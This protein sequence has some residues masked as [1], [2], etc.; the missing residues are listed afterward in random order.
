MS[1]AASPIVAFLA[2]R[3]A[4][5]ARSFY[6]GTLGLRIIDDTP[7]ALVVDAHGTT[8]RVQKVAEFTPHP[9]TALGWKVADIRS[10][11]ADLVRRGVRFERYDFVPQDSDG[12]WTSPDG[13]RVAWFKDPDGNTLSVGE[14]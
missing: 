10:T 14:H 11:I 6:E 9:F 13:T 2:T 7:F 4:A 12:V 1:L 8:V 5:R 3:D